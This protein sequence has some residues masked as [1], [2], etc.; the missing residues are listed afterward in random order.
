MPIF[1]PRLLHITL[2]SAITIS[3]ISFAAEPDCTAYFDGNQLT[4]PCV[5]L[6][7][8][9]STF[10]GNFTIDQ[11]SP[12]LLRLSSVEQTVIDTPTDQLN[13]VFIRRGYGE[14]ISIQDGFFSLYDVNRQSCT[15]AGKELP[16]D[17]LIEEYPS[18]LLTADGSHFNTLTKYQAADIHPYTYDRLEALPTQ[19]SNLTGEPVTDLTANFEA[20]W[21]SFND[22]YPFFQRKGVDWQAVYAEAKPL[23]SEINSEED[24]LG[25]FDEMLRP[26]NDIHVEIVIDDEDA[27]ESYHSI[28]NWLLRAIDTYRSEQGLNNLEQTFAEQS[29]FDDFDEFVNNLLQTDSEHLQ[30]VNDFVAQAAALIPSYV[31]DLTCPVSAVCSGNINEK[32][33]YLSIAAMFDYGDDEQDGDQ[34]MAFMQQFLADFI[35]SLADKN[36]LIIDVRNNVGGYD[37]ISNLIAE[38]FIEQSQV[39]YHKKAKFAGGFANQHSITLEPQIDQSFTKPVYVLIGEHTYSG[40]EVFALAMKSLPNAI[41]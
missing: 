10:A 3:Q 40:G 14:V 33:A 1:K 26:L 34:D 18:V 36:A 37:A 21:H 12:L 5:K 24:L 38:H 27:V 16:I 23:L 28:A 7:G 15:L 4:V 6:P 41:L 19:C 8:L 39:A 20:L 29:E 25:L 32:V 22:N 13:G 17:A 35:P 2:L 11:L 30:F 9:E 31:A